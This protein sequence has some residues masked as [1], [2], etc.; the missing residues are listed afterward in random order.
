MQKMK[1]K[2]EILESKIIASTRIFQVEEVHLRYANGQ[3]RHYERLKGSKEAAVMIAPMLD[4]DTILLIREY[5]VGIEDYSLAFPKGI[6]DPGEDILDAANREL[7]EETGYGARKLSL[8]KTMTNS[9]GYSTRPMYLVLAQDLYEKKLPGDEPEEIEVVPW[10]LSQ[11]SALLARDDFH[12]A[13]S[14]AALFLLR[15]LF[16]AK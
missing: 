16:H 7:M 8:L 2:P 3:E 10:S 11:S 15:D 12:E 13:R 5:G 14:I 4:D 6:V 1:K 9:P